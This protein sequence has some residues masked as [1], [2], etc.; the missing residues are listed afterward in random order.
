MKTIVEYQ[1]LVLKS[2]SYT[3]DVPA[4]SKLLSIKSFN[5]NHPVIF[6]EVNK[7]NE[8]VERIFVFHKTNDVIEENIHRSYVDTI[9]VNG[10][11]YHCY[12]IHKH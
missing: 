5:D 6:M 12:E 2:K 8:L 1:L 10:E 11:A 4:G 3:I 7:T 9:H